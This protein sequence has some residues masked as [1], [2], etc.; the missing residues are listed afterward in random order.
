MAALSL[1]LQ[2]LLAHKLSLGLTINAGHITADLTIRTLDQPIAAD[3]LFHDLV[4]RRS[5]LTH[6]FRLSELGHVSI[7]S[8]S[9]AQVPFMQVLDE[10]VHQA[11]IRRHNQVNEVHFAAALWTLAKPVC[12]KVWTDLVQANPTEANMA[13]I[14]KLRKSFEALQ[15]VARNPAEVASHRKSIEAVD[16]LIKYTREHGWPS[17]GYEATQVETELTTYLDSVYY[18]YGAR[19]FARYSAA[20]RTTPE[21]LA[22]LTRFMATKIGKGANGQG[23]TDLI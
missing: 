22:V 21:D 13:S 18:P 23:G 12:V 11:S 16:L 17:D 5:V 10:V 2:H 8:S 4:M 6:I 19:E 9:E 7:R 1:I 14:Q 15:L 3:R 20:S